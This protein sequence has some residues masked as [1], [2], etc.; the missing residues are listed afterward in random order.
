[1]SFFEKR[2][3]K[4]LNENQ[5]FRDAWFE[6]ESLYQEKLTEYLKQGLS[7]REAAQKAYSDLS[8]LEPKHD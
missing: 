8:A 5:S 1:L 7:K 6:Q 2:L 4:Q 3:E